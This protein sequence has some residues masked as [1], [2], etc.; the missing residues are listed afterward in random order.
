MTD[1]VSLN[2]ETEIAKKDD[3]QWLSNSIKIW[4]PNCADPDKL[5]N[6]IISSLQLYNN[7]EDTDD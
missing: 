1:T 5:A 2:E 3:L 4:M 7:A 6:F